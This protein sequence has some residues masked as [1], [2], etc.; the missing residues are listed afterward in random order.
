MIHVENNETRFEGS[1][2]KIMSEAA[3]A[4]ESAANSFFEVSKRIEDTEEKAKKVTESMLTALFANILKTVFDKEFKESCHTFEIKQ[5]ECEKEP[6]EKEPCEE[7][8]KS[9]VP[10]L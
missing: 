4:F 3:M 9:G 10:E 1:P 8:E 2:L 7:E 5:R 6:C